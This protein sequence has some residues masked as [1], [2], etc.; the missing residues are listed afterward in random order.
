MSEVGCSPYSIGDS[1]N[2]FLSKARAF[3]FVFPQTAWLATD[4]QSLAINHSQ[5]C[6]TADSVSSSTLNSRKMLALK[7]P[8]NPEE[9]EFESKAKEIHQDYRL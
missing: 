2:P 7:M 5:P 6:A 3:L 4:T 9:E 8:L 1:R